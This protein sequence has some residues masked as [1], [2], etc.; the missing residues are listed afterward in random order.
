[1]PELAF[2]LPIPASHAPSVGA[3]EGS[4]LERDE[5]AL[6]QSRRI[7]FEANGR[8][9]D[10]LKM[11]HCVFSRPWSASIVQCQSPLGPCLGWRAGRMGLDSARRMCNNIITF[12]KLGTESVETEERR[13]A[14]ALRL[15][16]R[17]RTAGRGQSQCGDPG[18]R[19]GHDR[20]FSRWKPQGY[21][22]S[23]RRH[24][25]ILTAGQTV[26]CVARPRAGCGV[27]KQGG[28]DD[29]VAR[30][31][32]SK[33]ARTSVLHPGRFRL[34]ENNRDASGPAPGTA[35]PPG[36]VPRC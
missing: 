30:T 6:A 34:S 10:T 17:R 19:E 9:N 24:A 14:L 22:L 26:F 16:C 3:Q 33:P 28:S 35:R 12:A 5:A 2:F 13:R 11:V 21:L 25:P 20:F 36:S 27:R 18:A 31:T 29:A 1:M 7:Y 23:E 8:H 4:D 32:D 15:F